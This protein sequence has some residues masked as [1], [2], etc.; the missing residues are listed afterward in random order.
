[1]RLT[2]SSHSGQGGGAYIHSLARDPAFVHWNL[3]YGVCGQVKLT[4]NL[5]FEG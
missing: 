4:L 5:C 1:M 3:V 2:L